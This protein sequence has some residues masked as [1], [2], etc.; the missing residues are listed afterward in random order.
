[1][2]DM[3]KE[4][5]G[6]FKDIFS[7]QV[8]HQDTIKSMIKDREEHGYSITVEEIYDPNNLSQC[9]LAPTW[10]TGDTRYCVKCNRPTEIACPTCDGSG[11]VINCKQLNSTI[12]DIP[13]MKCPD[14]GGTGV[15]Q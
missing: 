8:S 2:N 14:C 1:M 12:I 5:F 15:K 10:L 7:P 11:D 13:Y 9:C 4:I 3:L 6:D